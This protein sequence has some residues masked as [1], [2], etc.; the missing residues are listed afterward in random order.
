M[1]CIVRVEFESEASGIKRTVVTETATGLQTCV[2][3]AIRKAKK[4]HR[5]AKWNSVCIVV[6]RV[7]KSEAVAD[8]EAA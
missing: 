1:E 7:D 5:N 6:E 8:V 2:A 4:E 3:R